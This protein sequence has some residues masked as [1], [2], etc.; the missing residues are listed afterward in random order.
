MRILFISRCPP[1]PL[2]LGDRLILYHLAR[3]LHARGHTL[4]LLALDE[5]P[6]LTAEAAPVAFFAHTEIFADVPRTPMAYLRRLF[7]PFPRTAADVWQPALGRA[8]GQRL[9][10]AEQ[11][12][13]P[14]DLVHVF[15]GV[16]VYDVAGLLGGVPALITPYESFTLYLWRALRA[17]HPAP[18]NTSAPESISASASRVL[19][20]ASRVLV[21]ASRVLVSASRVLVSASRVFVSASR[22]LVSAS[23]VFVS[24]VFERTMYAPYR[25]VVVLTPRD[26]AVLAR[27]NPRYRLAVIPNGIDPACFAPSP[28]APTRE[29]GTIVFTGNYE[30]PPNAEAA[31]WLAEAVFPRVRARVPGAR[32][33]LV[34]H[35]PTPAMHAAST[36]TPGITVTGRVADLRPYLERAALFAAPLRVGAGIKNKVLEAMAMGCPVIGTPLAF[37]GIGPSDA[38]APAYALFS[39][40]PDA[41]AEADAIVRL[42]AN[43]AERAALAERARALIAARYTWAAVADAVEALY[44]DLLREA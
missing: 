9:A 4:D 11:A 13:L 1:V 40:R 44:H 16:Q 19:V 17:G 39:A 10:A 27:L 32:L 35:A 7:A 42:L 15:G 3:A 37:D 43:E 14:Y 26:A 18:G 25:R 29:A 28:G 36:R 24:A 20:S 30:Y 2:F 41:E 21:S 34:G 12:G 33:L 6:A 5:R 23:R 22:V 38:A 31:R 8:V